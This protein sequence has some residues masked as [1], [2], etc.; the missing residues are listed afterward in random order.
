MK[1]T[2]IL[3]FAFV[4]NFTFAHTCE[5]ESVKCPIDGHKVNFC[6]TMSMTTSGSYKDF[7][8]I[9]AIGSYYEELI[10][11]CSKCY[12]SGYIS[13]FK[14]KYSKEEKTII[15]NYLSKLN[16]SKKK[17]E[18]E[19]CIIAAEIKEILKKNSKE[20]AFVYLNS[21]YFL[22]NDLQKKELRIILQKKVKD[23]LIIA[24]K[25]KEYE[26]ESI[27]SIEYLI[28]EMNRRTNNF[29]EA[30]K[31]YNLA[32][33]NKDKEDWVEEIAKEQKALAEKQDSNNDI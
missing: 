20:I 3:F 24:I 6:V 1:K 28:A 21:T 23:N 12:F 14:E 15:K 30:I 10:N 16:K 33:N 4:F 26:V 2:L 17:N 31:Y 22:R 32:I 9:G 27:A 18:F 13:D 8:N 29:S 25:N 7:Q 11:T 19:Q 5:N